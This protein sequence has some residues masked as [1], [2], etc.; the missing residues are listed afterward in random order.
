M[1]TTIRKYIHFLRWEMDG[2]KQKIEDQIVF[3]YIALHVLLGI[4][5]HNN[6]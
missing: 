6:F 3:L 4:K 1:S 5:V 2:R